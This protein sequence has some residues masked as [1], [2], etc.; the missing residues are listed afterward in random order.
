MVKA[1]LVTLNEG[2]DDKNRCYFNVIDCSQSE[3]VAD[4]GFTF[5]VF[6]DLLAFVLST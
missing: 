4:S 6:T 5:E 1:I 2:F 3:V